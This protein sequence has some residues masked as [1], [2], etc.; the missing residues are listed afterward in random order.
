[1]D[2]YDEW[3]SKKKTEADTGSDTGQ[4]SGA[5]RPELGT[6]I[7]KQAS[8]AGLNG[9]A[10]RAWVGAESRGNASSVNAD[11][12]AHGGILQ[13]AKEGWADVAKAA[14]TPDVTWEQMLKLPAEKQI[15]YVL[16]YFKTKGLKATDDGGEYAMA[17][18]MPLYRDKP[19]DFVLGEEGSTEIAFGDVT[20]GKVWEQNP[21]LRDGNKI[22]VG[23]VKRRGREK[24]SAA[25]APE[26]SAKAD[27]PAT[28]GKSRARELLEKARQR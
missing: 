17:T 13:F 8:A 27:T 14:G 26:T 10:V 24:T 1:V 2:V 20:K 25:S 6:E 28:S 19:D 9:A 16:A 3:R 5:M 11:T 15:P 18:F 23:G 4:P 12:G 21:S 22:T 7:E